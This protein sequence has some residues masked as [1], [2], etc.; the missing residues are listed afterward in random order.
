MRVLVI[1]D[2]RALVAALMADLHGAGVDVGEGNPGPTRVGLAELSRNP[3]IPHAELAQVRDEIFRLLQKHEPRLVCSRL[4]RLL[5]GGGR[6]LAV[7]VST[8]ELERELSAIPEVAAFYEQNPNSRYLMAP[9]VAEWFA[10][11][12]VLVPA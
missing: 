6:Y 11:V 7:H 8:G 4:L 12:R 2:D 5:G 1:D 9:P 3:E 10:P